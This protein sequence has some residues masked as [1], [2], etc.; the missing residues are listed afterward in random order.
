MTLW[1]TSGFV[2]ATLG[3]FLL[4]LKGQISALAPLPPAH[5][6]LAGVFLPVMPGIP[7]RVDISRVPLGT[8]ALEIHRLF[9]QPETWGTAGTPFLNDRVPLNT[10]YRTT[11][12][13]GPLP[14][15]GNGYAML[16]HPM[17]DLTWVY[18]L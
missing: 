7:N 17:S 15:Q 18:R 1:H 8:G 5:N 10:S 6:D 12:R 4:T 2:L 9:G 14:D 16:G 11:G 13:M 3:A